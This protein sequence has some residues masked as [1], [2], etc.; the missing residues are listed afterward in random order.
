MRIL[1]LML[2]LS[3]MLA[4]Q[5]GLQ[6]PA[7]SQFQPVRILL[8]GGGSVLVGSETPGGNAVGTIQTASFGVG[9]PSAPIYL[10]LPTDVSRS[11][12]DTPL[13]AAFDS[14][15]NLWI[16]GSTTSDDFNLVNPIVA[17]KAPNRQ[18]GFVI[19][20]DPTGTV[21]FASYLGGQSACEYDCASYASTITADNAGN[22]YVAG[23][24]D[25]SDFPTTPGAFLTSG[26]H[27]AAGNSYYYSFVM[28]ISASGKLIYSTFLGTGDQTCQLPAYACTSGLTIASRPDSIAVDA[29][30]RITAAE[31]MSEGPGRITRLSADGSA[32]IWSTDTGIMGGGILRLLL[33]QD[34][35]GA[36]TLF[37]S[38]APLAN[39][40]DARAGNGPATLFVQKVSPAGTVTETL[41]LG[42]AS[43][44]AQPSGIALDASGNIWLDG[45]D[46]STSGVLSGGAG[47]GADFLLEADAAAMNSLGLIRFFRGVVAAGLAIDSQQDKLIPGAHGALLTVPPG[48]TAA[49]PLLT[50]FTNSASFEMNTGAYP[51]ALVSLVGIGFH[52]VPETV[53]IAGVAAP[54]LYAGPNQINVQVPFEAIA[55]IVDLSLPSEALPSEGITLALPIRRSLGIFT[56][57]GTHAAAVNQDGT[58]N[59]ASNPAPTGSVVTLYGTGA[60][61]PFGMADGGI[62]TAAAWLN[63]EQ[64]GF[65]VLDSSGIPQEILYAGAAPE[66]IDGVF[67]INVIV[68]AG[69]VV[70]PGVGWQVRLQSVLQPSVAPLSSNTVAIYVHS[71]ASVQKLPETVPQTTQDSRKSPH[72][73]LI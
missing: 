41:N 12:V 55:G 39:A 38:S 37:G 5:P 56:T 53:L 68:P 13:D 18:S 47:Q 59:S 45:T 22:V 24:T 49:T 3:P 8:K 34:S 60:V 6:F 73:K 71:P 44:D 70:T 4:A 9:F 63:Q 27:I 52:G 31:S 11:G 43:A 20:A 14:S 29:N 1:W 21:K 17:K 10:E 69:V 64:N 48:Y 65:Q 42:G 35:T 28:K 25:E 67:Q 30:G 2:A 54:V 46:S 51:G 23:A 58:V 33:A 50:G 40:L 15:G 72:P 57:D 66:I 36:V 62:P 61:W 26:P 7:D 32:A 16:V 19:E